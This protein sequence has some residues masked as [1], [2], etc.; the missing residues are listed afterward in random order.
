MTSSTGQHRG[1]NGARPLALGCSS[2]TNSFRGKGSGHG[3]LYVASDY[4][5]DATLNGVLRAA[6]KAADLIAAS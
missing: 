4:L 5:F 2:L 6:M 3:G 1:R